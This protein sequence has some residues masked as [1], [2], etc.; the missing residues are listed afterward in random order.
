ML[1]G[2]TAYALHNV[3]YLQ[4]TWVAMK[5]PEKIDFSRENI[6][7]LRLEITDTKKGGINGS[8][9]VLAFKAF[10]RQDGEEHVTLISKVLQ[11]IEAMHL[12]G[13]R[14]WRPREDV[15]EKHCTTWS[16]IGFSPGDNGL[17]ASVDKPVL[18]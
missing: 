4:E 2:Y 17:R 18:A 16:K 12:S 9:S 10:Y 6:D 13:A 5:R 11:L 3:A 14:R 7:R 15:S 8:K 1:L